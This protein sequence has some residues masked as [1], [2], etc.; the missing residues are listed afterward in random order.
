MILVCPACHTRYLVDEQELNRPTG[1][2]VRCASCGHTWHRPPPLEVRD[3]ELVAPPAAPRIEPGLD[4]PP[5]PGP[6]PVPTSQ[7]RPRNRLAAGWVVVGVIVALLA[8]A[9]LAAIIARK[10]V[11]ALW[12]AAARF[13]AFAG[14]AGAP[15]GPGLELAKIAPTRTAEGLVIEGDIINAGSTVR[16]V[17]RLRVALRD[18]A[19]KETQFKIIDPPTVRLGP[20]ETT[21]FKTSFDHPDEAATGVLVTFAPR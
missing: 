5:R 10:E 17:P 18:P 15:P 13:Y 21:H 16:D 2:T 14:L 11:V 8:S 19:E 7:R 3:R 6:L 9:I 12:P 4:V 20:G 1:R